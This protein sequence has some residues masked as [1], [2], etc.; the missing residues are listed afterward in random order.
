MGPVPI[1]LLLVAAIGL[2]FGL[3]RHV[4]RRNGE[5]LGFVTLVALVAVPFVLF[6]VPPAFDQDDA[7]AAAAF[8]PCRIVSSPGGSYETRPSGCRPEADHVE[9]YT[10]REGRLRSSDGDGIPLAPQTIVGHVDKVEV[11][12]DHPR[13]N[14]W[15]ANLKQGRPAD[16]IL[17]FAGGRFVGAVKPTMPRPDVAADRGLARL[18][19]SGYAVELPAAVAETGSLRIFAVEG[20]IASPM[21]LDCANLRLQLGC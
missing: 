21:P 10:L 16:S 4:E 1:A 13:I 3:A 2:A 20:A 5:E 17:F 14:G 11:V 18:A 12:D 9:T 7:P 6:V 19:T 15:A 8:S